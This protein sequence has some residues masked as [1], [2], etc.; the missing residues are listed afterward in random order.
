MRG[1]QIINRFLSSFSGTM[2]GFMGSGLSRPFKQKIN[3]DLYIVATLAL[4]TRC[5]RIVKALN[6]ASS[7]KRLKIHKESSVPGNI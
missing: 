1:G 6:N 2:D 4:E 3:S 5:L 7:T